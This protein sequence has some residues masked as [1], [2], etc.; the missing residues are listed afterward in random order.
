MLQ[1]SEVHP[2]DPLQVHV[3]F[4]EASHSLSELSGSHEV[5]T[6]FVAPHCQLIGNGDD[7]GGAGGA[8]GGRIG[9]TTFPAI[10]KFR[11]DHA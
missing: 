9:A 11:S 1:L 10:E 4:H 6:H 7:G 8:G 5:H 2:F 3:A